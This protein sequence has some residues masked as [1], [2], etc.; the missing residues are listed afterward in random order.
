MV[1][2]LE[3]AQLKTQILFIGLFFDVLTNWTY[4]EKESTTLV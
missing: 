2:H 4:L 3:A 1:M